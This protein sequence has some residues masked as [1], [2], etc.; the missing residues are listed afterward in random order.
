[1]KETLRRILPLLFYA[2]LIAYLVGN[3]GII[4]DDFDAMMRLKGKNFLSILIPK[5]HFYFIETP[6]EYFTHYIWY[7][8]FRIDNQAAANAFKI[9]YVIL[10][11]CLISRFFGIYVDRKNAYLVTFLF[12]FFP[13]HDST[14]YWFMGQYLMLSFA[15]YLYAFYLAHNKRFVLAFLSA[16]AASF[17]SYGSTALAIALFVLFILN[18]EVKKG[19]ALLIPNIIYSS[20]YV[21]LSKTLPQ[22]VERLPSEINIYSIIKQFILQVLTFLDATVGPS[23]WF[24]VYYSFSQLG[25]LSVI[26]GI[27]LT[28][29]LYRKFRQAREKYDYKLTISLIILTLASLIMFAV[30]GYYPELAFNLGNRVTIFGSLLLSYIIVLLPVSHKIR[31]LIFSVLLFSILGVSDHWKGW[32]IRQETV[33]SNMRNNAGLKNYNDTKTIYVSGNQY[34][35]FGPISHI[36]FL[37]ENWVPNSIFGLLFDK[38]MTVESLNKKHKYEDG[39][40]L[41]TKYG[42][43]AKV[44][45]YIYVYDSNK[46]SLLKIDAS[47]INKYIESLPEEKRHWVQLINAKFIR[48][49]ILNLMPRLKYAL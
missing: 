6:V 18:K 15:F 21:C 7:Y 43:K 33:I 41:D 19:L 22:C 40:L 8:F 31:A 27:L 24:K 3:T 20:Y 11:F 2:I 34:S 44:D 35:R 10:A 16:L 30:T 37:S 49:S 13:S 47:D 38:K 46:N 42:R 5:G 36:E 25:M 28:I 48:N 12:I 45:K 29:L 32:N 4:S 9:F 14:I 26:I 39:F 17:V 1:M 23:M